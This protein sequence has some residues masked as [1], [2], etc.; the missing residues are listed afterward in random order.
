MNPAVRDKW[1]AALK[2]GEY[3]QA[4]GYLRVTKTANPGETAVGFCCLGVLCDIAVKDGV[5]PPGIEDHEGAMA[6]GE[7]LDEQG[8]PDEVQEWAGLTNSDP[9]FINP[10]D[11][12]GVA[13]YASSWNDDNGK[14]FEE[15]AEM[16]EF[17]F[18][19]DFAEANA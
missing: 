13:D 10:I 2:S 7:N 16:I 9:R 12:E 11:A 5:I 14:T 19:D 6:Y 4:K 8:L 15:I 1:V 3:E 17:T 18:K